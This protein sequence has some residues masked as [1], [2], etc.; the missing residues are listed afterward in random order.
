MTLTADIEPVL[1]PAVRRARLDPVAKLLAAADQAG[2]RFRW[3]GRVLRVAG[4]AGLHPDDQELLRAHAAE[5]KARL[6]GP[7]DDAD[8]CEE[9]GVEVQLVTDAAVAEAIVAGLP[10]SV[11]GIDIE[12]APRPGFKAAEPPWLKITRKGAPYKNQPSNER[13][14]RARSLPGGA[15][16]RAGV[17]PGR[18]ALCTCSTSGACRSRRSPAC[19]AAGWSRTTLAFELAMLAR[20]GVHPPDVV[21]SMQLVG[22][23]LG[24]APGT[25]KLENAARE[26]LGTEMPKSAAAVG[27]GRRAS[28]SRAGTLC[29]GR[30]RGRTHGQPGCL[31]T[32][33]DVRARGLLAVQRRRADRGRDADPG[34]PV[35]RRG[36]PRADRGMGDGARRCPARVRRAD[37][38]RGAEARAA[39]AR[40]ARAA[41]ARGRAGPLAAHRRPATC[42]PRPMTWRGSRI[43]RRSPRCSR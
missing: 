30:C 16:H 22:L 11:V 6:A 13:Q 15:A 25:R 9:W 21:D 29:G 8:P 41:P 39:A 28:V 42:R 33:G 38:G 37:R 14:D 3:E 12:T 31:A 26:L 5:I 24:C 32:P 36:A 7:A 17:R 2:V 1:V 40:L 23:H 34:R 27:L 18:A 20:V 43:G 19:G 10:S 4:L 35:R